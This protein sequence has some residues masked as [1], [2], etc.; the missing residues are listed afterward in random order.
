MKLREEKAKIAVLEAESTF[1]MG[2]QKAEQQVKML[3]IPG[4]V[5]RAKA[6]AKVY[7][8]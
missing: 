8:D 4:E 5:V 6:R 3:Q 2:K 1:I 7:E